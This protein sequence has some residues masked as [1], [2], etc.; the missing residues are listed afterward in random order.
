MSKRYSFLAPDWTEPI[1]YLI[2]GVFIGIPLL[3]SVFSEGPL[4]F[5]GIA[6]ICVVGF[7][8][9]K[10]ILK[11]VFALHITSPTTFSLWL[12][13]SIILGAV[14]Y[15]CVTEGFRSFFGE[16]PV[17]GVFAL[18]AL[19]GF[20]SA[21]LYGSFEKIKPGRK[22]ASS[23]MEKKQHEIDDLFQQSLE[24]NDF[25]MMCQ[26]VDFFNPDYET[27]FQKSPQQATE[28]LEGAKHV[29][30]RLETEGGALIYTKEDLE[31]STPQ[32]LEEYYH[33]V[34]RKAHKTVMQMIKTRFACP[35][36]PKQALDYFIKSQDFFE[37]LSKESTSGK[38]KLY[39]KSLEYIQQEIAH[40]QK[41]N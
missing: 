7:W 31:E 36:E 18:L 25:D 8:I 16:D 32:E 12:L 38:I 6:L 17:K 5:C 13:L 34:L 20:W 28:V 4:F 27:F 14:L 30:Y 11:H 26:L 24:R 40:L 10:Q 23:I 35:Q 1:S 21:M 19:F 29:L 3:L 39:Q 22:P 15:A 9:F 2:L 37:Q 41:P 33:K